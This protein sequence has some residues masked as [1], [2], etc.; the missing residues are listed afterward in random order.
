MIRAA[1]LLKISANR[2]QGVM[3]AADVSCRYGRHTA[4]LRHVPQC[5]L[6]QDLENTTGAWDM[7]GQDNPKRYNPL[8]NQFFERA[9]DIL[10]RREALN[11]FVALCEYCS[12]H[13]V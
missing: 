5:L 10:S 8:Q 11:G 1:V 3:S 7:Y 2:T 4:H 13:S 12:R 6:L 9:G